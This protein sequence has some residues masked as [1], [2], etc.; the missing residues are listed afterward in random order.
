MTPSPRGTPRL[1][2]LLLAASVALPTPPFASASGA[3][4][5]DEFDASPAAPGI[6]AYSRSTHPSHPRLLLLPAF[7]CAPILGTV[8]PGMMDTVATTHTIVYYDVRGT[9][10]SAHADPPLRSQQDL[11]DDAI[12]VARAAL[13]RYGQ[14]NL[15][16]WGYSAGSLLA[17]NVSSQAPELVGK[18][19]LTGFKVDQQ[20]ATIKLQQA[21]AQFSGV[22][23]FVQSWL[24]WPVQLMLAFSGP[25]R[26]AC[27]RQP[28]N[29][30]CVTGVPILDMTYIVEA[31]GVVRLLTAPVQFAQCVAAIQDEFTVARLVDVGPV[32]VPVHVLHGR[33]DAVDSAEFVLPALK[34]TLRA[35]AY[36]VTWFE[37]SGHAPMIEEKERYAVE[38]QRLLALPA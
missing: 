8:S 29:L 13:A 10:R 12:A 16:I 35:P 31:Y 32:H 28:R 33:H 38:L 37:E 26:Y 14:P 15:T 7:P 4:T 30:D 18:I 25:F 34:H 21:T 24:P 11:V 6:V 23:T 19:V 3:V 1:L 22:S 5:L 2:V 17:L 20:R 9:L 27:L 36:D